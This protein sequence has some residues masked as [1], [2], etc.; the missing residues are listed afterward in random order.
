MSEFYLKTEQDKKNHY[1][2]QA[3]HLG[4]I[5]ASRS[6]ARKIFIEAVDQRILKPN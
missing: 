1:D 2:E 3:I 6:E 4:I 5:A